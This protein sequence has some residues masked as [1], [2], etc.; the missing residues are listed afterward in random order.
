MRWLFADDDMTFGACISFLT[1]LTSFFLFHLLNLHSTMPPS[2]NKTL[3]NLSGKWKLNKVLSDDIT[4]VLAIQGTNLLLRKTITSAS[5]TLNISQPQ[6]NEYSIKQTATSA[7]IPGT[8][9]QYILDFE[10]R[11]NQDAFFGEVRGRSKWISFDEVKADFGDLSANWER[12]DD[13]QLI[14]TEGGKPDASWTAL[15]IWGFEVIEGE[16]RYTQQVKVWNKQG[17]EVKVKMVYDLIE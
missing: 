8:T 11:T 7:S 14:L 15:R 9:E 6:P 1:P 12:E 3:H 5:V 4:Q 13:S 17:E 2:T 10:W 16:R